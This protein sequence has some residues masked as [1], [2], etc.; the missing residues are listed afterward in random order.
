MEIGIIHHV[1]I[2]QPLVAFLLRIFHKLSRDHLEVRMLFAAILQLQILRGPNYL[3]T[4]CK[5]SG[6]DNLLFSIQHTNLGHH[7]VHPPYA[8][9]LALASSRIVWTFSRYALRSCL[10]SGKVSRNQDLIWKKG[11]GSQ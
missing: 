2:S 3:S 11:S 4:L 5:G 7:S 10:I 6:K 9:A 1:F 8:A